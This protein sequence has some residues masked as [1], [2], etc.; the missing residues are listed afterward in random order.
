MIVWG[1]QFGRVDRHA[2]ALMV[3]IMGCCH[4]PA[5]WFISLQKVDLD[6]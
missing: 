3:T 1:S 4:L 5:E 2:I 6:V